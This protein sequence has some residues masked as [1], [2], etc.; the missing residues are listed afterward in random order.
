MICCRDSGF[1]YT[2]WKSIWLF[3]VTFQWLG[4]AL[5]PCCLPCCGMAAVLFI[6]LFSLSW[7]AWGLPHTPTIQGSTG[8]LDTAPN[9]TWDSTSVFS[10]LQVIPAT[11]QVL[12]CCP[13]LCP[14]G[15]HSSK[16][17]FTEPESSCLVST[18]LA[19]RQISHKACRP[20]Q[21]HCYLPSGP[22][23]QTLPLP[24]WVALWCLHVVVFIFCPAYTVVFCG[25]A[26]LI[27]EILPLPGEPRT[28]CANIK[29][30]RVRPPSQR[31]LTQ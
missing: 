23:I 15:G 18:R 19:L 24:V 7:T 12:H 5:T 6:Q 9:R 16:K 27:R 26:G 20:I 22:V 1:R 21:C 13:E 31:I 10:P 17:V 4:D 11:L 25:R 8:G 28:W 29:L 2:S 14:P 3:A 30:C